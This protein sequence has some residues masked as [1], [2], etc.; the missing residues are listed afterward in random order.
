[1]I[2]ILRSLV[3]ASVLVQPPESNNQYVQFDYKKCKINWKYEMSPGARTRIFI[4]LLF[5]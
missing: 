2:I 4:V 3:A 5:L 1:M